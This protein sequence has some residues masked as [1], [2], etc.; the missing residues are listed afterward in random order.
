MGRFPEEPRVIEIVDS[1]MPSGVRRRGRT[2]THDGAEVRASVKLERARWYKGWDFD[3][4]VLTLITATDTHPLPWVYHSLV[5]GCDYRQQ[6]NRLDHVFELD[7]NGGLDEQRIAAQ[8]PFLVD[9]FHSFFDR[10]KDERSLVEDFFAPE[11]MLAI[12]HEFYRLYLQQKYP[13]FPWRDKRNFTDEELAELLAQ[14]R[15]DWWETA[16]ATVPGGATIR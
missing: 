3:S 11:S 13:Q 2:W 10:F 1:C 8:L 6:R 16:I 5:R 9:T 7:L 12:G 4:V 15:P 14:P